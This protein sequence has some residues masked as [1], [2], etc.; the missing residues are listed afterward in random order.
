VFLSTKGWDYEVHDNTLVA[1]L[2]KTACETELKKSNDYIIDN[3]YYN[4]ET[5][6]VVKIRGLNDLGHVNKG[7]VACIRY[8]ARH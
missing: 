7:T 5:K 8:D 2:D 6:T 1:Y 3:R 4:G